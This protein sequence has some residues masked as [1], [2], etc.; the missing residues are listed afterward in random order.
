MLA[1]RALLDVDSYF[2]RI[3]WTGPRSA[4]LE[5]LRGLCVRHTASVPF[6]NLDI[7]LGRRIALDLESLF[8][9]M[10]TRR[11]GGYCFEQNGLF[12][13][14]LQ[15]IGFR[16]TTLAGRVRLGV[17]PDVDMPR[18]HMLLRVDLPEGPFIVDVGFGFTPT[19][20]LRLEP[21]PEQKLHLS[22]YRFA[23][24]AAR[25]TLEIRQ[26]TEFTPAY[27]FTEEPALPI[28]YEVANHYTSTHPRSHFMLGPL[29]VRHDPENGVRHILR[30]REWTVRRGADVEAHP[31]TSSADAVPLLAKHFGLEFPAGTRFR[32]ID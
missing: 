17:A 21:G 23:R 1:W 14:V 31:V 32:G 22:T 12:A 2:R 11:R 19:A 5:V 24:D 16:V 15:E 27:V 28:D 25:W 18:T 26:P 4:T 3:G 7:L 8:D 20:P 29:V 13:A 30:A 10:V 6:E 9:K